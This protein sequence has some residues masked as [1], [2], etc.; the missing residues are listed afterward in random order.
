M[1]T[2]EYLTEVELYGVS[3]SIIAVIMFPLTLLN[4]LY[5]FMTSMF[6]YLFYIW[7]VFSAVP[8][9][10]LFGI[11]IVRYYQAKSSKDSVLILG[12]LSVILPTLIHLFVSTFAFAFSGIYVIILPFPL[13]FLVGLIILQRI[14]GPEVISP[15]SGMRLDL[16]WWKR[17]H[18]KKKSDWD[19]LAME[20]N[21]TSEDDWLGE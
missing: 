17:G 8:L 20:R 19:P 7:F 15:W 4:I 6:D 9:H 16:S 2:D 10:I 13:Q 14:E 1:S 12:I 21:E 3:P 11:W 5:V 18:P